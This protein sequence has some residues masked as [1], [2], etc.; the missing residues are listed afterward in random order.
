VRVLNRPQVRT[1]AELERVLPDLALEVRRA[2]PADNVMGLGLALTGIVDAGRGTVLYSRH[3]GYDHDALAPRLSE[4]L[5]G[6]S[7]TLENDVNAMLLGEQLHHKPGDRRATIVM[8]RLG[9]GVGGAIMLHGRLHHGNAHMAGEVSD[10]LTLG[11]SGL[12]LTLEDALGGPHLL[13]RLRAADPTIGSLPEVVTERSR[14]PSVQSVLE[15]AQVRLTNSIMSICL[16]LAPDAVLLAGPGWAQDLFYEPIKAVLAEHLPV[17]VTV[18]FVSD[19]VRAALWGAAA[20]ALAAHPLTS[21]VPS[22][23]GE[24]GATRP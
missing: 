13:G 5:G 11:P 16:L 17:P 4:R 18:R 20:V 23:W 2:V 14:R 9:Q 21:P 19:P 24:I 12:A 10:L 15:D 8:L 3:L 1:G 6:L 7:V 22:I